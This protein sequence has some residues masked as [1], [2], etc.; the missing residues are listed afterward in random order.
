MERI[1]NPHSSHNFWSQ[2]LGREVHRVL[3]TDF[4]ILLRKGVRYKINTICNDISFEMFT[5]TIKSKRE[6]KKI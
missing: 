6:K 4:K 5:Q 3:F 2:K 1:T